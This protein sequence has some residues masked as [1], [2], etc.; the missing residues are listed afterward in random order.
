MPTCYNFPIALRPSSQITSPQ[1]T[2]DDNGTWESAQD[3][4]RQRALPAYLLETESFLQL[5][6]LKVMKRLF[7][8]SYRR[9][10]VYQKINALHRASY[11]G[12]LAMVDLLLAYGAK[13]NG[14]SGHFGPAL[15]AA[16]TNDNVELVEQLIHFGADVNVMHFYD[17]N[18]HSD[19]RR[20]QNPLARAISHNFI[21]T[22]NKLLELGA[23][24]NLECEC[25]NAL[26][27]AAY[28]GRE[29]I[30]PPWA[31]GVGPD[32]GLAMVS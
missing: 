5:A 26:Q 30:R 7:R 2:L 15:V 28:F 13:A 19:H 20:R 29:E 32:W 18:P 31:Q 27:N 11:D 10:S 23:D 14:R 22:V 1:L 6:A 12:D 4:K 16:T 17:Q 9:K 25:G 24:I 3:E 8:L 21:R